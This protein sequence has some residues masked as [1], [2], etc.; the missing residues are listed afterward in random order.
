MR[1]LAT[2]SVD[3]DP[4]RLVCRL[5]KLA[6]RQGAEAD[7][8]DVAA[9]ALRYLHHVVATHADLFP[10]GTHQGHFQL[11]VA[12]GD[13][14]ETKHA[15][16]TE[17][18]H[19][20]TMGDQAHPNKQHEGN[21]SSLP[22]GFHIYRVHAWTFDVEV[23]RDGQSVLRIPNCGGL[24]KTKPRDEEQLDWAEERFNSL[25]GVRQ[26][27]GC[28]WDTANPDTFTRAMREAGAQLVSSFP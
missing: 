21:E 26:V 14:T 23:M 13:K 24:V 8:A 17:E 9:E 15:A 20:E 12:A 6:E 19:P 27:W 10:E 1:Q 22:K 16:Q 4:S 25:P 2:L 5:L 11:G 3:A 18:K 7:P 28:C